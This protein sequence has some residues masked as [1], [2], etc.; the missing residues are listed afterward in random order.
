MTTLLKDTKILVVDDE[1]VALLTTCSRLE[2]GGFSPVAARDI[3][4]A[5]KIMMKEPRAFSA[6]IADVMMGD[7]DGFM[8]RKIVHGI[9]DTMPILFFTALDPAGDSEFLMRIVSDANSYYLPK[10]AKTEVLLKRVERMVAARRT[11]RLVEY[12]KNDDRKS[13]ELA[14]NIQKSML[15][16]RSLMTHRG[17]YSTWW[18]PAEVV[19]GDLYEAMPFGDNCR[20]FILGDIRG[21]GISAAMAMTAV[22]SF[23]KQVSAGMQH[24]NAGPAYVAN[25]LQGFFRSHMADVTYM[26][27]LIC[28]HRPLSEFSDGA[29]DPNELVPGEVRWISCGAPDLVVVDGGKQLEINPEHRGGLP[30]GLMPDVV[31]TVDDE[32]R[33]QITDTAICVMYSD[34]LLDLS[35]DAEGMETLSADKAAEIGSQLAT[36]ARED[37]SLVALPSKFLSACEAIGYVNQPDDVTVFTFGER[38][39]IAGIYEGTLSL[40]VYDV[41]H[42]V[43]ELSAWCAGQGWG[44]EVIERIKTVFSSK[45]VD[46]RSHCIDVQDRL[47]EVV[48]FRLRM[49]KGGPALTIWDYVSALPVGDAE[50]TNADAGLAD[51]VRRRKEICRLC[52]GVERNHYSGMNETIYH[53]PLAS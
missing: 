14:A 38:H 11:E 22:L 4:E 41:R 33:T 10:S 32:V 40:S 44:A 16:V 35:K 27:A 53:I 8:L 29:E 42:M 47:Q 30:I 31:Y 6:V 20:M 23:L 1:K 5:A 13:L 48:S 12:R 51:A 39:E 25:L 43:D 19:S 28:I 15:P 9:D 49:Q 18:R 36:Y 2:S 34:G 52:D 3:H 45:L 50:L 46:I 7:V 37:A 21:H 24:R 17:C 26:T